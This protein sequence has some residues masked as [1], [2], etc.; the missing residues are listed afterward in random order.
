MSEKS[1]SK[2][3]CYVMI[4]W[5]VLSAAT[6]DD[7]LVCAESENHGASSSAGL[8]IQAECFALRAPPGTATSTVTM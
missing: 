1:Q 5:P 7:R 2:D 3:R 6:A 4:S 8:Y